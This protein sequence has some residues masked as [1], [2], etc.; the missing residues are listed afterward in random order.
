MY[1]RVVMVPR[2]DY[3]SRVCKC[4]MKEEALIG[5]QYTCEITFKDMYNYM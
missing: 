5:S 2:P 3:A 4:I 1:Q